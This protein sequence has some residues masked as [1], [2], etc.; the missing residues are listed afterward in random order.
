MYGDCVT[1]DEIVAWE[2]SSA[3]W[4]DFGHGLGALITSPAAAGFAALGAA[5]I[6]ARQV[7]G[8]RADDKAIA[9]SQERWARFEWVSEQGEALGVST[10]VELLL[11]LE[12]DAKANDDDELRKFIAAIRRRTVSQASA[13]V[14]ERGN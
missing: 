11:L 13:R 2:W 14:R 8:T 9:R 7:A 12:K 10:R 3:F 4:N 5:I 6:A 1:N